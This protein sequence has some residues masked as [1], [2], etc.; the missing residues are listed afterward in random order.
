MKNTI[1]I[2]VIAITLLSSCKE[3]SKNE[4]AETPGNTSKIENNA[5]VQQKQ[6]SIQAVKEENRKLDSIQQVRAHGHAH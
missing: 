5:E 2:V 4:N 6:D 3:I 1:F